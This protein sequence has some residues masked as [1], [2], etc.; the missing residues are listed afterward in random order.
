MTV[1]SGRRQR[2]HIVDVIR[3]RTGYESVLS[4][5][6]L[7]Q[8]GILGDIQGHG[9]PIKI[10]PPLS[11]HREKPVMQQTGQ[12]HGHGAGGSRLQDQVDILQSQRHRKASRLVAL[13]RDR[14]SIGLI[15]RQ[16]NRV[17]PNME[18]SLVRSIPFFSAKVRAS[19]KAS[20]AEA[21]RKFPANLTTFAAPGSSPKS[22]IPCP[23][24]ARSAAPG[25]WPL[26]APTDR[27]RV[28]VS[29]PPPDARK[30]EPQGK[31]S[32]TYYGV[33]RAGER[34]PGTGCSWR[35]AR[36]QAPI[37]PEFLVRRT[38][39]SRPRGRRP[40]SS[41][42]CHRT[43]QCHSGGTSA[44]PLAPARGGLFRCTIVDAKPITGRQEIAGHCS[45]HVS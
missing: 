22:K 31:P 11:H 10:G 16:A 30:Q 35:D 37:A 43:S 28:S 27:S 9:R 40:A 39:C 4:S 1:L 26:A 19:A 8:S 7:R 24:H 45:P 29:P 3:T 42:P 14:F 38:R 41:A 18:A 34:W 15:G 17:W 6:L 44:L 32:G 21:R 13:L 36:R 12:G 25:L 20:M 2:N 33:R 23:A 5:L